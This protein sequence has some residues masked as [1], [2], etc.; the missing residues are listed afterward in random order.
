[1]KLI[2]ELLPESSW[3]KNLRDVLSPYNWQKL[4]QQVQKAADFTCD[5]CGR[6]KGGG[7]ITRLNCHELWDYDLENEVQRLVGFQALCFECHCVK[8]IGYTYSDGWIDKER[9]IN[10]FLRVNGATYE[11]FKKHENE[12]FDLWTDRSQ[13]KWKIDFSDWTFLVEEEK[14]RIHP[15]LAKKEKMAAVRSILEEDMTASNQYI[16]EQVSKKI[17]V[18]LGRIKKY[19]A[20]IRKELG[21][22]SRHNTTGK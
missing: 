21:I 19:A 1:M 17:D 7:E 2:I 20:E 3:G 9:I 14:K 13:I 5:I 4:S 22:I 12:A 11:E 18:S 15:V 8:H 6:V 10:H 16:F